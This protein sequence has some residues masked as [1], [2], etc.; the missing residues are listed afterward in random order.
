MR[1]FA[2]GSIQS[3]SEEGVGCQLAAI[4]WRESLL[5]VVGLKK[6]NSNAGVAA[7]SAV[8]SVT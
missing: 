3:D 5:V 7:W 6:F 1:P 4:Y 2:F 8:V